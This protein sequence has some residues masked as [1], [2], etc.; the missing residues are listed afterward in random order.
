MNRNLH[1]RLA[2]LAF[3]FVLSTAPGAFAQ[4]GAPPRQPFGFRQG[5]TV[6]IVAFTRTLIFKEKFDLKY[7]TS[8]KAR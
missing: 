4:A 7:P 2:V 8:A 3:A 5:Q 6:Y 1:A